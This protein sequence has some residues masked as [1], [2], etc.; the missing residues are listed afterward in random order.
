MKRLVISLACIAA[1]LQPGVLLG[2]ADSG[3]NATADT[4]K[5][6]F[7]KAAETA[8]ASA[9]AVRPGTTGLSASD[10]LRRTRD[11]ATKA[12]LLELKAY[13]ENRSNYD[14]NAWQQRL[15]VFRWHYWSSIFI[16]LMVVVLITFAMRMAYLEFRAGANETTTFKISR[17][18][19]EISSTVIGL[20]VLIVSLG[21]FYLYLSEVY[22]VKAIDNVATQ[23]DG[24]DT[25][26]DSADNT[27][28]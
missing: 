2:A 12:S 11:E 13:Y 27:A 18:G 4:A 10:D 26:A 21:F 5:I 9:E 25:S 14:K 17:D 28:K 23:P 8:R 20:I 15:T 7:A 3:T 6:D 1:L 24:A 22:P 19:L 16:F